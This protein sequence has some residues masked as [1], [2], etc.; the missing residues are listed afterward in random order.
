MHLSF[1]TKSLRLEF[2]VFFKELG[3]NLVPPG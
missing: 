1:N 2:D 3:E